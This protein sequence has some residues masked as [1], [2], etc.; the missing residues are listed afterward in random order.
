VP[1]NTL[2][3]RLHSVLFGGICNAPHSL[4]TR[5]GFNLKSLVSFWSKR[6]SSLL[7]YVIGVCNTSP[8]LL[9]YVIG[10][11]NTSPCLQ[12][13]LH[14][15]FCPSK[16]FFWRPL[17]DPIFSTRGET[18]RASPTIKVRQAFTHGPDPFQNRALIP[19]PESSA[20][21]CS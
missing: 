18:S 6:S 12:T 9:P 11:C 19:V 14:T 4:H 7:P 21:V 3:Q 13:R 16:D 8:C 10:V 15:S 2:V 1:V 17:K 5:V 20:N